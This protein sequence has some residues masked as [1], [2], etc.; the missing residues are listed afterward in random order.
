MVLQRRND[1]LKCADTFSDCSNPVI[2]EADPFKTTKE[3]PTRMHC[4]RI[5]IATAVAI[6]AAAQQAV[7]TE[8]SPSPFPPAQYFNLI[9]KVVSGN[10]AFANQQIF[11]YGFNLASTAHPLDGRVS[12][13]GETSFYLNATGMYD[14]SGNYWGL[15]A[16][17]RKCPDQG[18]SYACGEY[19][20]VVQVE[21]DWDVGFGVNIE[22]GQVVYV[23]RKDFGTFTLCPLKEPFDLGHVSVMSQ[24]GWRTGSEPAVAGCADVEL[25]A[26]SI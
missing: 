8:T 6:V 2:F 14:R 19:G 12:W 26:I 7:I 9:T 10:D 25:I 3:K 11:S 1:H 18:H 22:N 5:F 13:T 15:E 17:R 4:A 20:Y 23:G 24:L 21:G 16:P